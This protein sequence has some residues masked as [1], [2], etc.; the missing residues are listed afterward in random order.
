MNF[1]FIKTF[2]YNTNKNNSILKSDLSFILAICRC[3]T[4]LPRMYYA[5]NLPLSI[6]NKYDKLIQ[7][8][9]SENYKISIV[10][11]IFALLGR[12]IASCSCVY[13]TWYRTGI[14]N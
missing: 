11:L 10:Y 4:V 3:Y 8:E 7:I 14:A 9:K 13:K 12:K 6:Y 2:D 1:S 5:I